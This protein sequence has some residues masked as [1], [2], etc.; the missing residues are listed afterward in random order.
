MEL[1]E[2]L[3]ALFRAEAA[4]T[5]GACKKFDPRKISPCDSLRDELPSPGA[6]ASTNPESCCEELGDCSEE[7]DDTAPSSG[8]CQFPR[9]DENRP[10]QPTKVLD[11]ASECRFEDRLPCPVPLDDAAADLSDDGA[12]P[13]VARRTL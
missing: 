11:I 4:S 10:A 5:A 7:L 6:V 8:C 2:A 9:G 1:L 12:P 13:M 3:S